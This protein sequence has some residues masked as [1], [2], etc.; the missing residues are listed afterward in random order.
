[1]PLI[2]FEKETEQ[3]CIDILMPFMQQQ[4][5]I[6]NLSCEIKQL[7]IYFDSFQIKQMLNYSNVG[8]VQGQSIEIFNSINIDNSSLL[9]PQTNARYEHPVLTK[10]CQH[11]NYCFEKTMALMEISNKNIYKCPFCDGQANS[12]HDLVDDWRVNAYK[13]FNEYTQDVTIIKGI[14]VHRYMRNK[15]KYLDFF[16]KNV[17]IIQFKQMFYRF[18]KETS[19]SSL[20][21]QDLQKYYAINQQ[22]INFWSFCLKDRVKITIPVRIFGCNHYECYELTSLLFYQQQNRKKKEFLECNQPGCSN[23]LKIAHKDYTKYPDTPSTQEMDEQE[24][25]LD[26]QEL[27]SG[28][29]VDQDLLDAIKLSNPSSQKFYYNKETGKIQED[30]NIVNGQPV[31]P[32]I[33]QF[34]QNQPGLSTIV[35]FQEFQKLIQQQA[36]AVS[37]GDLLQENKDLNKQVNL[38]KYRNYKV[39]MKDKFTNLSIEYPV[40]CRLCTNLEICMDMRSYIAEYIYRKKMSL[41]NPFCCPLCNQKLSEQILKINIVNQIYLDSNM[42]SYMFKDMSYSN[43]TQIFDYKGEQY[44]FQEFLDRQKIKREN[45]VAELRERQV[46]FKQLFCII[47][48]NQRIKQPL[49]LQKCPDR[50]IVDFASFYEEL[51]K[52]NFD[53]ENQYLILCRCNYCNKNPIKTFV[54][55]IYFHEAFYEALNKFYEIK[56]IENDNEFSYQFEDTRENS[57]VIKNQQQQQQKIK[58][59]MR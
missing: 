25:F 16:T 55:N 53:Y 34:Y 58:I 7:Y 26:V 15:K 56:E 23:K 4:I 37:Q 10:N 52:I 47:N 31:D 29:F 33:Y 18:Y 50:K 13:E 11:I 8:K 19:L 59:I 40:R 2:L 54:G 3:K 35:K 41:I 38:Y 5:I 27:F 9:N 46:L 49:I 12:P 17:N 42:L 21:Q 1:M 48:P 39:N 6:D 43:G 32:F 28:I 36:I 51:K 44:M 45:Y 24:N 22:K 30:L 57:Y 20:I 14:M